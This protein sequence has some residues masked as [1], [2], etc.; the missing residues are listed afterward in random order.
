MTVEA[1]TLRQLRAR[2]AAY[3]LHA[4]GGTNTLPARQALASKWEL[5]VDPDGVLDPVERS[6]RAIYAKKAFFTELAIKSAESRRRKAGRKA[7]KAVSGA[8]NG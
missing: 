5:E 7:G 2:R 4:G 8:V 1:P 6:R 3:L